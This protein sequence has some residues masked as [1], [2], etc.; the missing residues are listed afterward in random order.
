MSARSNIARPF[1]A[2]VHMVSYR[3][4][5]QYGVAFYCTVPQKLPTDNLGI[6]PVN[7]YDISFYK[8][9]RSEM[10]NAYKNS[11]W[12]IFGISSMSIMKLCL[13]STCSPV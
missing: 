6:D 12:S 8:M 3:K 10:N 7:D 2:S 4:G 9:A 11:L 13:S 5:F 1:V